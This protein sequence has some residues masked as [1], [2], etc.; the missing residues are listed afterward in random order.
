M[1]SSSANKLI[2]SSN[3]RKPDSALITGAGGFIGRH[4]VRA[5][6]QHN[7]SVTALMLPD[8]PIPDE[9]EDRVDIIS[10]DVRELV[11][12]AKC[13]APRDVIY[14][15]AAVVSDWGAQQTHVDITVG[16]TREAIE[17]ALL[18]QARFVVTTSV[19]AYGDA[20][21]K[22]GVN[23][24]TPLG[25]ATSPYEICKQEQERITLEAVRASGLKGV[26]VR[27]GNV[28]GVGSGPWV[29]LMVEMLRERKPCLLGSGEWDAGLCHVDNLVSLLLACD[30][31]D[32]G[33]IFIAADGQGVSWKTYLQR[34]ASV[35]GT[36]PPR[37]I[38]NAVARLGAPILEFIGRVRKQ[39]E[40]PLLTRQSLR[41]MGGAN[42]FCTDKARLK[43]GFTPTT[44]FD[45]AMQQ[46]QQ[47]F[48]VS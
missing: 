6:L 8:E 47:Q 9:W 22:G 27:P 35:A 19:C 46:L 4:L 34:L 14:H 17:L 1:S 13:L 12:L 40:R 3:E 24:I 37:S 42:E 25:R 10:G 33:D 23:E 32:A 31:A 18:W 20:L 5:L 11:S 30:R 38:P 16:G 15:L 45:E 2:M 36:P 29:N 43:L 41:L 48:L 44:R 7:H 28:Y 26:I 39:K 21:A